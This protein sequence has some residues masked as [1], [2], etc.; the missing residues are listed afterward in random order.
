MKKRLIL[1]L[2]AAMAAALC[3]P[4]LAE[5]AGDTAQSTGEISDSAAEPP[6][7]AGSGEDDYDPFDAQE[8][9][10]MILELFARKKINPERIGVTY[11]Y[12]PTGETCSVNG[13]A[14][15]GGASL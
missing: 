11:C 7:D 6:G 9:S 12:T 4:V 13:S 8:L 5:D 3:V 14:Y 1:I 2:I 15:F 10:S